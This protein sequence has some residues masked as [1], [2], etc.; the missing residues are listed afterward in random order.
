M[1]E[2]YIKVVINDYKDIV[3]P[4]N[5]ELLSNEFADYIYSQ[6][7]LFSLK[8]R[9]KILIQVPNLEKEKHLKLFDE[10]HAYFGKKVQE[11]LIYS[12]RNRIKQL[13]L[14]FIGIVFIL[15]SY[16][17]IVYEQAL[18]KEILLI[19]GWVSIWEAIYSVLFTETK[20]RFK[21]KRLKQLSKCRIEFII[22]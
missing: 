21:I 13:I 20:R 9:I 8:T 11:N 6:S 22:K 10:I 19:A 15:I 17:F 4:F 12:N 2:D 1:K 16:H 5:E 3:N 7:A 18:L 14:V